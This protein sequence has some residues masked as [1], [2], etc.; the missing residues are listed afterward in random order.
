MPAVFKLQLRGIALIYSA[1][2]RTHV[3]HHVLMPTDQQQWDQFHK[4]STAYPNK[5]NCGTNWI[6]RKRKYCLY[7]LIHCHG[8]KTNAAYF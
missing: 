7:E 6:S 8:T 1:S 2:H 3:W 4:Y 5:I